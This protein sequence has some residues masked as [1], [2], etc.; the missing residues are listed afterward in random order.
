RLLPIE[1]A[2]HHAVSARAS[3]TKILLGETT[4]SK[5][6]KMMSKALWAIMIFVCFLSACGGV[7]GGK[8]GGQTSSTNGAPVPNTVSGTVPF[9]GAPMAG[10]TVSVVNTNSNP[11]TFFASTT[12]DANGNYTIT[13]LS[14]ACVCTENYQFWATKAGYAFVPLMES[15]PTGSL[16]SYKWD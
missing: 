9:K 6:P 14:T 15:N 8:G 13:G 16:V 10:V 11:S 1:I 4:L 2:A 12:T 5:S 7:A 3:G